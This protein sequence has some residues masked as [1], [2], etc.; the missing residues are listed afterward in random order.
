[1][2][3]VRIGGS[4]DAVLP[5]SQQSGSYEPAGGRSMIEPFDLKTIPQG[6]GLSLPSVNA[7]LWMQVLGR[8][9]AGVH[10]GID[11]DVLQCWIE[12]IQFG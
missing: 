4:K 12:R 1:L 10:S 7:P 2:I 5:E 3:A 11:R 8:S 9:V 6:E